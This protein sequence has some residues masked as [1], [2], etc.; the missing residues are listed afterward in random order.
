MT[1]TDITTTAGADWAAWQESW[2]RQQ[3]WYMPDREERL[4][5]RS[6]FGGVATQAFDDNEAL[7]ARGTCRKQLG[8]AVT[9][10]RQ[11]R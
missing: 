11:L 3:E 2:D 5:D 6:L 10:S 4:R 1:D 9:A 8:R 7:D